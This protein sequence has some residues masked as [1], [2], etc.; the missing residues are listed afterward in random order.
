M[1]SLPGINAKE[2]PIHLI[3]DLTRLCNRR[4]IYKNMPEIISQD[5]AFSKRTSLFMIDVDKFKKVN[6]T[7][8]HLAGDDLLVKLANVIKRTVAEEGIVARYGGDEFLILLPG[9]DEVQAREFSQAIL[10]N[11]SRFKWSIKGKDFAGQDISIGIAVYP[12]DAATL[13]E[14][15]DCAD[16]ALYAAKKSSETKIFSYRSVGNEIKSQTILRKMLLRPPLAGRAAELADLKK[17]Y[18]ISEAGTKQKILVEGE[19]GI[20][21]TRLLQEL[22]GWTE[23]KDAFFLFCK[24]ERKEEGGPLAALADLLRLIANST[25]ADKFRDILTKLMPSELSEILYLYPPAKDFVKNA[26]SKMEPK[27]RASNLISALY[28]ILVDIAG[29]KTL[30]LAVD[31]LH[32]ANQFTLRFFSLLLG[33][34]DVAKCLFI[35]TYDGK[36]TGE[37]LENFLAKD[38][39]T[40]IKLN[41]F[42]KDEVIQLISSIFPALEAETKLTE[43]LF[44]ISKGNPLL[45]CQ[46]LS[47]LVDKGYIQYENKKWVLKKADLKDIPDSLSGAAGSLL[48]NL[49]DETKKMLALAAATGGKVELDILTNISGYN[50]GRLLELLDRAIRLGLIDS[51]DFNF[52][53]LSF[54]TE[55]A[56]KAVAGAI[57]ASEAES[58]HRKLAEFI[59]ERYKD[60][61]PTQLDRLIHQLGLAREK[62][63]ESEYKN[64]SRK[65]DQEFSLSEKLTDILDRQREGMASIEEL[66]ERPLSTESTKIIKDTILVM[67]A[68]VMGTLIYPPGNSM[69]MDF[70]NR[71]YEL[72]LAILKND[73]IF[74]ISNIEGKVLVNG[75]V[76][77][78]VDV[79][80]SIGFTLVGM[81]EDYRISSITFKSG[82]EKEE[83][84]HFLHCLANPEEGIA[85]EE[86]GFA[87]L[88]KRKG[89]SHVKINHVR[90]EKVSDTRKR[91]TDFKGGISSIVQLSKD[92]LLDMPVETYL[93][94]K[95]L[96]KIGLIAEALILSKDNEKVKNMVDKVS[97]ALG[98]QE[99]EETPE[100]TDGAIRL[101]ESLFM[102]EKSDLLKKLV[103]AL[104]DRF[105]STRHTGEFT[106]LCDW[107]Q[108]IAVR[109]IDKRNFN[110]AEAIINNFKAQIA[111]DSIR[112]QEQKDIIGGELRTISH[113][114]VVEILMDAF[115]EKL[116]SNSG[117]GIIE[118]LTT[119]GGYALD[120]ML[121][122]LTRDEVHGKDP[123]EVFVMLHSIAMVLKKM[124]EPAKS[125]LKKMLNDKRGHVVKNVMEMLG[126]IGGEEFVPLLVP[127][128]HHPSPELRMQCVVT[129]K[130]IGTKAALRALAE[131]LK[132]EDEDIREAASA[133]IAGLAG[134]SFTK[135]RKMQDGKG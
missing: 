37:I 100:V 85:Q 90:Y 23:K 43:N 80:N 18:K 31:N 49:D 59:K 81:M 55:P 6:D 50:E 77:K 102:Y 105:N 114:K 47:S 12:K 101:S 128:L 109:S 67:K 97:V 92:K 29:E 11:T 51:P 30:V 74:T 94:P 73:P 107:L 135:K 41:P 61:L 16:Q 88:L 66:L 111:A 36:E 117:S 76:P 40:A 4:F 68:A 35:G 63:S 3:D 79:K 64:F 14:L 5:E 60:E 13:P 38:T 108:T 98:T 19:L 24:L 126:Y 15:I 56:R 130:R 20:G 104:I 22:A 123:F 113:P 106:Q 87:A 129:L 82:L 44:K 86:G 78:Y 91:I 122:I 45:L 115:K 25:D 42:L 21:K 89:I 132:D 134:P 93:D 83:F 84:E 57:P 71:A 125:A 133:A 17:Y 65:M 52:D 112:T 99:M 121:D 120:P 27:R 96:S 1:P 26:F 69:R 32:Y 54:R 46:I 119:L 33:V 48:D 28:K 2:L 9:K 62:V 127:L 110:Q 72:I 75:Y 118:M 70:E 34:S 53:S 103:A 58:I 116:K 7:F 8:G 39:F 95:L 131:S 10:Q 124:G